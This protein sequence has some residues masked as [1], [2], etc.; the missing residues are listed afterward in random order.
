[1]LVFTQHSKTSVKNCRMA[2]SVA[3]AVGF[4]ATDDEDDDERAATPAVPDVGAGVGACS[5]R[6]FT[7]DRHP[8][9]QIGPHYCPKADRRGRYVL[10]PVRK[11]EM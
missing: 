1:M 5:S 9:R 7:S 6:N 8:T 2:S 4:A 3:G 11:H 10:E